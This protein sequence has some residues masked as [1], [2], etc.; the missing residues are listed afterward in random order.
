MNN[1]AND[2]TCSLIHRALYECKSFFVLQREM[3]KLA[4][5]YFR[6]RDLQEEQNRKRE[7]I[8]NLLGVL[9][10]FFPSESLTPESAKLID[11]HEI[12]SSE[13]RKQLKL[14][15]VLKLYLESVDRPASMSQ[16]RDFLYCLDL[17]EI[18]AT[19]QAI[20]SAIKTHADLF[21]IDSSGRER[22]I[23]LTGRV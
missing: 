5:A 12:S 6:Y 3:E 4:E 1:N 13:K 14:W 22:L 8:L 11:P 10:K 16:F 15:E 19:P 9:G 23:V 20:E 21:R 7:L 2:A 17:D 18:S